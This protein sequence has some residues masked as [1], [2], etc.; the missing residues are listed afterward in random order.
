MREERRLRELSSRSE[1]EQM[2]DEAFERLLKE[3]RE[4][5]EKG[6]EEIRKRVEEAVKQAKALRSR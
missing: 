4:E 2:V 1:I 6:L 5:A 3:L